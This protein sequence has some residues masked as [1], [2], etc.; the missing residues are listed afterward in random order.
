MR[1]VTVL[2]DQKDVSAPVQMQVQTADDAFSSL[3][4][5]RDDNSKRCDRTSSLPNACDVA[6]DAYELW[7]DRGMTNVGAVS[8]L[9]KPYDARL[10]RCYDVSSRINHVANDDEECSRP[11]ELSRTQHRLFP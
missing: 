1:F 2:C 9:L 7:L 11:V 5:N 8:E 10:M 3:S 6:P 4:I